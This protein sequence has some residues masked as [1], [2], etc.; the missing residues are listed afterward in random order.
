MILDQ[1]QEHFQALRTEFSNEVNL[2]TK[3]DHHSL[4]KIVDYIDQGNERIIITE[5]VPNGTL[6]E[7]LDGKF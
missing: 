3:I 1:L 6:R 4:V 2:L 7:H 5:Y